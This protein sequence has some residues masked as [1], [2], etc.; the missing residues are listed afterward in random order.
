MPKEL[1]Y[2]EVKMWAAEKA[3]GME[4]AA[5]YFLFRRQFLLDH[6]IPTE[7]PLYRGNCVI[8]AHTLL[9]Q[10]KRI[11]RQSPCKSCSPQWTLALLLAIF[12]H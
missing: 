11:W 5:G 10:G 1:G 2:Y 4:P 9:H 6:P 3:T 7:L 8:H 12:A